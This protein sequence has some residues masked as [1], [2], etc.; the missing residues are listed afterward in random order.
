MSGPWRDSYAGG[1]MG[2]G[3][4]AMPSLTPVAK[5]LLIV[6]AAIWFV[7]FFASRFGG[8]GFVNGFTEVFAV[9]PGLWGDWA[10]LFP[11][12][13]VVTYGFV[14]IEPMHLLYNALGIYFFGTMLEGVLGSRRFL[15]TY[16]AAVGFSGLCVLLFGLLTSPAAVTLGA[17]GGVLAIVVAMAVLRPQTPVI[18]LIFPMTLKVMAMIFVGI[19]VLRAIDSLGG[20]VSNVS[21]M[22]HLSGAAFGFVAARKGWIYRDPLEAVE[23][24][25]EERDQT[26]RVRDDERLDDLLAKIN[27]EGLQSLSPSEKAFLKRVS[28]RD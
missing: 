10:P 17:S 3:G 26:K 4:I 27:R 22:A 28:K 20:A 1:G 8:V 7:L 19:D 9:F 23:S 16:L 2:G 15:A 24:W 12:W 14:H 13:Q 25:K 18:F 11:I 5:L 21:W 6:N